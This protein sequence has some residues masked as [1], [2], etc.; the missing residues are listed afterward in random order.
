[1]AVE[2]AEN[3]A[4]RLNCLGEADVG[5]GDDA[6]IE[7]RGKDAAGTTGT[8]EGATSRLNCLGEVNSGDSSIVDIETRGGDTAGIT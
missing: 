8:A 1:M 5:D 3:V 2:L 6:D 7:T 4:L